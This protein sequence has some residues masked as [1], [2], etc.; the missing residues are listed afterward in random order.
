MGILSREYPEEMVGDVRT[1]FAGLTADCKTLGAALQAS[2]SHPQYEGLWHEV[3][4]R[5]T[6]GTTNGSFLSCVAARLEDKCLQSPEEYLVSKEL[7]WYSLRFDDILV[8]VWG[9]Y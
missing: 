5:N 8:Q 7:T 9:L 1:L 3:H 4:M 2:P 6:K